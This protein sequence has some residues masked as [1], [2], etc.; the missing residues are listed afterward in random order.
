M[1]NNPVEVKNEPAVP[2]KSHSQAKKSILITLIVVVLV[3]AA[4]AGFWLFKTNDAK[5]QA[6]ATTNAFASDI[7]GN[8]L[9]DAYQLTSGD[10]RTK[11]PQKAFIETFGAEQIVNAINKSFKVVSVSVPKNWKAYPVVVNS[12][13]SLEGQTLKIKTVIIKDGG[14]WVIDSV[15]PST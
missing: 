14:R 13:V 4:L 10:F 2:K 3:I 8:K 5:K 12:E 11:T 9:N 6:E 1:V 15:I 7:K